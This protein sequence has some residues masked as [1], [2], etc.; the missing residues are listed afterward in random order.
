MAALTDVS[1]EE[2]DHT[3][4][5]I[6]SQIKDGVELFLGGYYGVD[7][8]SGRIALLTDVAGQEPYGIACAFGE[9]AQDVSGA[10]PV[11]VT[12]D[13]SAD[14]PPRVILDVG[15]KVGRYLPI[16]GASAQGDVGLK[17]YLTASSD[18][19]LDLTVT[20]TTSLPAIG[21]ITDFYS[22]ASFEIE[23]YS[24]TEMAQN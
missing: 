12:G 5:K 15:R 9:G 16:A 14:V 13:T 17:V 1:R 18:N 21:E 2:I 10:I 3:E 20:P 8:V 11:N 24:R 19:V 4:N 6:S 22:S 23:F 7:G